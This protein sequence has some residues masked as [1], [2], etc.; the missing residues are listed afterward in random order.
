MCRLH[1]MMVAACPVRL[2]SVDRQLQVSASVNDCSR[3]VDVHLSV[4]VLA[5]CQDL[6]TDISGYMMQA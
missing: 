2:I 5:F 3:P 4:Q 6:Q 1:T